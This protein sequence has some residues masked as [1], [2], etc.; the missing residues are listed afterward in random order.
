MTQ[1][2]NEP[3]ANRAA[4]EAPHPRSEAEILDHEY[5][6]I[7]EY[8]NPMPRWWKLIFWVSFYFSLGYLIHYHVTG[9]GTSVAAAYEADVAAAREAQ[10]LALLGTETTEDSLLKLS[11]DSK[12]MADAAKL[13]A[14][15]CSPC[16]GPNA[17]GLIGPNLTD[18][19]WLNGDAKLLT[20]HSIIDNGVMA[21]GMP[22]W[23]R[24]LRPIETA[25]LAAYIGTLRNT[26][27]AGGKGPEGHLIAAQ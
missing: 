8:D 22:A 4:G 18:G 9:N 17:E 20:I 23:N 13:F 25:K 26:N 1:P 21:K 15:R 5:D 6:G 11:T 12:M 19:Y 14:V 3:A 7:R 16:H 27:H 10:A 24:Q 2:E